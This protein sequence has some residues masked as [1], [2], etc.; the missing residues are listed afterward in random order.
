MYKFDCE[1]ITVS[2]VGVTMKGDTQEYA[3]NLLKII[4]NVRDSSELFTCYNDPSNNVY[5]I[6]KEESTQ[7]VVDWLGWFGEVHEPE[8]LTGLQPILLDHLMTD[9]EY[10]LD[11]VV[12]P[13]ES[14]WSW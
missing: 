6:C 9:K 11:S 12:L 7:A 3:L 10:D 5:V 2:R 1:K 13:A 14:P 4:N 8:R